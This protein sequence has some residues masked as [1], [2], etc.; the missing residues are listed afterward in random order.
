MLKM[1]RHLP[2]WLVLTMQ[3]SA[4]L[5]GGLSFEAHAVK[6]TFLTYE[7]A[8]IVFVAR[9]NSETDVE[10]R[11]LLMDDTFIRHEIYDRDG[12][13]AHG[14]GV[15]S[16][17]VPGV[18]SKPPVIPPGDSIWG[19]GSIENRTVFYDSLAR[20]IYLPAGQYKAIFRW[21]YDP[22]GR[23][24][25]DGQTVLVDSVSFVVVDPVGKAA[26][27]RDAYLVLL[28]GKSSKERA[29]TRWKFFRMYPDTP[30]GEMALSALATLT[31]GGSA[32]PPPGLTA[33]DVIQEFAMKYPDN[34][35][36]KTPMRRAVRML[37]RSGKS[38]SA[39][40]ETI[41]DSAP[42][43]IAGGVAVELLKRED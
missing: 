2:L 33:V 16:L 8:W 21:R 42:N 18:N 31:S 14:A 3:P 32:P 35:T 19:Y 6:D 12:K 23:A 5:S 30:Y 36:V 22:F 37:D 13:A 1:S 15:S 20:R 25:F 10:Y 29:N 4:A 26:A 43:T 24:I 7:E 27:A 9:N 34:P 39:F 38:A 11:R 17:Y 40:L 28:R 41:R